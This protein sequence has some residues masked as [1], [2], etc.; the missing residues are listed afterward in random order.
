MDASAHN[1][2]KKRITGCDRQSK[3]TNYELSFFSPPIISLTSLSDVKSFFKP[4]SETETK[5]NC[6][7]S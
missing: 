5:G 4:A 6:R 1:N 7:F 3:K 2:V